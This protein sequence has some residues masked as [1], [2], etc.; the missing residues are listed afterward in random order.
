MCVSVCVC[1]CVCIHIYF[2]RF[3]WVS[4]WRDTK[5]VCLYVIRFSSKTHGELKYVTQNGFVISSVK[6]LTS[7]NVNKKPTKEMDWEFLRLRDTVRYSTLTKPVQQ[8]LSR[9]RSQ[10]AG[11]RILGLSSVNSVILNKLFKLLCL[12]F[13]IYKRRIIIVPNQYDYCE[14][15]INYFKESI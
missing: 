8:N 3:R 15:L 11:I 10:I 14:D 2:K 6:L 4:L 12:H 13:L 7:L 9:L 1:V 5:N